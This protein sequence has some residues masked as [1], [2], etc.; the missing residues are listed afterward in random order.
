[1]H[2]LTGGRDQD[3]GYSSEKIDK[4]IMIWLCVEACVDARMAV[5]RYRIC[6][7]FIEPRN[8]LPAWRAGTIR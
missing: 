7:L 2:L 6:K 1:M 3:D 5:Y 4:I 8:R